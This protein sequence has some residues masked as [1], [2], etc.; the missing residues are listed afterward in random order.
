MRSTRQNGLFKKGSERNREQ[1]RPLTKM[2]VDKIILLQDDC[3]V[4]LFDKFST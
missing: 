2:L 4:A 3:G 1:N